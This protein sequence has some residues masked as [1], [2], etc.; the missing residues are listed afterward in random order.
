MKNFLFLLMIYQVLAGLSLSSQDLQNPLR[1][2]PKSPDAAALDQFINVP[3][4]T[5][6]GLAD[7]SIPIFTFSIGDFSIPV[8]LTYHGSGIK[9]NDIPS[10]VGLGWS[11]QPNA[12]ISRNIIGLQDDMAPGGWFHVDEND[13]NSC[14]DEILSD[15]YKG[16]KDVAPDV[17]TY[18][19]FGNSGS[20]FFNRNRDLHKSIDDAVLLDIPQNISEDTLCAWDKNGNY[21]EFG[22]RD[23]TKV[24]VVN[25]HYDPIGD[26]SGSGVTGWRLTRIITNT[27]D[28][29]DFQYQKYT[30]S[31]GIVSSGF[32]YTRNH[33]S[34]GDDPPFG[35]FSVSRSNIFYT[36]N[37][38]Q[39]IESKNQ[40]L[41][42]TYED[43]ESFAIFKKRLKEMKLTDKFLN[44]TKTAELFHSNFSPDPR[45]KLD[46]VKVYVSDNQALKYSFSYSNANSM[47]AYSSFNQD[48]FGYINNN[49][50]YHMIPV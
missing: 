6:S 7:V 17:F 1:V 2:I 38:I 44:V 41:S 11:L 37:L 20:F 33:S 34:H 45:I 5:G 40:I 12:L 35:G 21:Y 32:D 48:I 8:A 28:T 30:Y 9:V 50:E 49:T 18:N 4:N 16:F 29:I 23:S 46:S 15:F 42:F 31:T 10:Q 14:H 13:A 19:F 26:L 47:P 25:T 39:K 3:V 43:N 22:K 27:K 24:V 36:T